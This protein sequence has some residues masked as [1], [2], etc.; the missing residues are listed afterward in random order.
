MSWGD[1]GPMGIHKPSPAG[2]YPS[3]CALAFHW[4]FPAFESMRYDQYRRWYGNSGACGCDVEQWPCPV[5]GKSSGSHLHSYT[6][7]WPLVRSS[8]EGYLARIWYIHEGARTRGIGLSTRPSPLPFF[9]WVPRSLTM[10]CD[11]VELSRRGL[12]IGGFPFGSNCGSP[13]VGGRGKQM[14]QCS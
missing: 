5:S 13:L 12:C 2:W 4:R 3:C 8:Y 14:D 6:I 9:C 7:Q 1:F 11:N 10:W